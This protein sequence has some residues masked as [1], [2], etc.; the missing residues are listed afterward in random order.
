MFQF[1][2]G[3]L[4]LGAFF[5]ATD[6]VTCPVTKIGKWIGGVLLGLLVILIRSLSGYVEGVM[7]SIVL[8]NVFAPLIDRIV[9]DIKYPRVIK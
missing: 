2:S 7:F 4:L 3:G 5:M 6:P 9:L 8:L 1:L